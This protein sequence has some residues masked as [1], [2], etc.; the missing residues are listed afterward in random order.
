[1]DSDALRVV[2]YRGLE[3]LTASTNEML[4]RSQVMVKEIQRALPRQSRG[5]WLKVLALI[6]IKAVACVIEK[7]R[8]IRMS[9]PD[10]FDF[11]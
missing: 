8:Q 1:M 9:C 11:R 7:Q 5:L 3:D 4:R 6:A 10:C 2:P